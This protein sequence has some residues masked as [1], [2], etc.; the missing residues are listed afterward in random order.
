MS[1][2]K[3]N[4]EMRSH[5]RIQIRDDAFAIVKP[6]SDRLLVNIENL[7]AGGLAFRYISDSKWSVDSLDIMLVNDDFYLEKLAVKAVSDFE[8][9][10]TSFTRHIKMRKQCLA[11]VKPSSF[12]QKR[13]DEFIRL[14][15]APAYTGP[16][17]RLNVERRCG[18]DRRRDTGFY[19]F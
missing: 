12:Q 10:D 6:Q 5:K 18:V 11:F 19:R 16:E 1:E 17:R 9:N 4:V 15:E 14:Y 8:L 7:S 3:R 13:L 2:E